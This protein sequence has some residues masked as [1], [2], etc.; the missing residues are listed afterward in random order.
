MIDQNNNGYIEAQELE[1]CFSL[2][3]TVLTEKW[4]LLIKDADTD[5]NGQI[6]YKEFK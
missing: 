4:E 3:N 1:K 5:G 2:D 6:D